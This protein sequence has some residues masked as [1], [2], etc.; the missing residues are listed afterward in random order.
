MAGLR[1][2]LSTLRLRPRG[3][4]RMTRGRDDSLGLSRTTLSFAT[5]RRFKR[6]TWCPRNLVVAV[7]NALAGVPPHRSV[8][9]E[10]P[11]TALTSGVW[12][13]NARLGT[14]AWSWV[15]GSSD[16]RA[17]ETVAT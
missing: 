4:R 16:L 15:G 17:A 14:G 11:H 13:R 2:P 10:L 9:A 3:R 8:R 7:G 6:R 1:V 5:L 12:R